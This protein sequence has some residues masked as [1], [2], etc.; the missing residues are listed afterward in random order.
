[1]RIAVCLK[2]VWRTDTAL[3]LDERAVRAD[4]RHPVLNPADAAAL[5]LALR[6]RGQG[7][8]TEILALTVGPP[9]WE[10]LLRDAL[11]AG[12]AEVLRLGIPAGAESVD[13]AAETT[14]RHALAAAAAL[15]PRPPALVLVGE[16]SADGGHGCFGAVLAHALGAAFAHRVTSVEPVAGGWRVVAE[17]ERGYA[18]RMDLPAPAVLTIPAHLPGLPEADLPAFLRSRTAVIPSAAPAE[19]SES[20]SRAA[21]MLRPPVPRVKRYSLPSPGLS[22]EERIRAL[23][24]LPSGAGG[25]VVGADQSPDAQ[26]E[27]I[28]ALLQAR[29]Y[30]S[31]QA[32]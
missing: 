30:L 2:A 25:T 32:D 22:A 8:A 19:S 3:R 6:L 10:A 20:A 23:V 5:A 24:T 31:P 12:V 17:L 29:G 13:G 7:V 14:R 4:G 11:A 28:V 26:A 1:M 21:T 16:R 27:V 9:A 18:Q 15:L